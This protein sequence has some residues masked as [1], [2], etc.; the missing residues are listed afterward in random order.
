MLN[1]FG[2]IWLLEK[3]EMIKKIIYTEKLTLIFTKLAL[4]ADIPFVMK[5]ERNNEKSLVVR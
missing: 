2:K 3:T 4:P 1:L 5:R